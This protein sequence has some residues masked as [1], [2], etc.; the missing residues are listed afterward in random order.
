VVVLGALSMPYAASA[1]TNDESGLTVSP[2]IVD[3]TVE[4]GASFSVPLTLGNITPR[5]VPIEVTKGKLETDQIPD[6][7]N[8][9]KYD[10][11]SWFRIDAPSFLLPA[12]DRYTV[13]ITVSVP[14][15]A[16]PGGHYGTVFFG[17]LASSQGDGA[18]ETL[19]NARVGVVFLLTVRGE[20][21]AGAE[22]VNGIQ[23]TTP[24]W[25]AGVSKFTFAI[26]NTGNVHFQ[27]QGTFVIKDV[28]GRKVKVL[29][30]PSGVV[31]PG[32]TR[33]Y[34]LAW[35]RGVRP[36]VYSA[37]VRVDAGV[38]L[39][40]HSRRFVILPLVVVIP[41]GILLLLLLVGIW[42]VRRMKKR[43]ARRA[44][45][46]EAIKAKELEEESTVKTINDQESPVDASAPSN[47]Q[48]SPE[49]E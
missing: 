18:G 29:P 9:G 42:R 12:Q 48:Q 31:L 8:Q 38:P 30:L 20:M 17:A 28:F 33:N 49:E 22:L 45:A 10:I 36:G 3:N 19:L 27:P 46:V 1:Q 43:R 13:N 2:A 11:S 25:E 6:A 26:H 7:A 5:A 37:E 44:A 35:E 40:A 15:D 32:A 47:L 16:E 21:K 24:Q 4:P 23:T 39:Q 34:E 41:A 14:R